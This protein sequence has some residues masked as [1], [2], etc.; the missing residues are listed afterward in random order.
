MK[1]V[2]SFYAAL[3]IALKWESV[4]GFVHSQ[5]DLRAQKSPPPSS[6]R[7]GGEPMVFFPVVMAIMQCQ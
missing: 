4:K 2:A 6:R 5:A 1:L 7:R 3:P